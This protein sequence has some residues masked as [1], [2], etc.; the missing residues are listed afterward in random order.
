MPDPKLKA[1]M[2]EIKVILHKHDIA[3]M[4]FLQSP[5][6]GEFLY[7]LNPSWSCVTLEDSG[8]CRIQAK[9][10]EFPS[11]EAQEK[12]ITESVGMLNGFHD[13]A[14]QATDNMRTMLKLIGTKMEF[15]HRSRLEPPSDKR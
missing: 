13:L 11:L 2:E 4:V 5:Q 14:L 1:A 15:S 6:N 9:R 10:D 7:H 8:V 3:G 12:K